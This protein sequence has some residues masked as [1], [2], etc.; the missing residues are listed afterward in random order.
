[1]QNGQVGGA[2]T[3]IQ[4]EL[5]FFPLA[6][7]LFF[8]TPRVEIDGVVQL[9]PWG[10]HFFPLASGVHRIRIWFVYLSMPQCG[11]NTVDL[12]L[13]EGATAHVKYFMPPWMFI[14]GSLEVIGGIGQTTL[15]QVVPPG[16][17]ADPTGRH[18]SRYWDGSQWT[19]AVADSGAQSSD[20]L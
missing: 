3:G 19:A 1:M 15:R 12:D 13:T 5:G 20:P 2:Q 16:W 11:L 18:Q 6:F 7:F 8:C 4:L 9:Q 17:N 14:P 10:E